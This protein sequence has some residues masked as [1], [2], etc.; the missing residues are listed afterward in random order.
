MCRSL[1]CCSSSQVRSRIQL[2][3]S[4]LQMYARRQR[5]FLLTPCGRW[6]ASKRYQARTDT[7]RPSSPSVQATRIDSHQMCLQVPTRSSAIAMTSFP[8]SPRRRIVCEE[9]NGETLAVTTVVACPPVALPEIIEDI[10]NVCWG[11]VMEFILRYSNP[12]L[13]FFCEE[14]SHFPVVF[15]LENGDLPLNVIEDGFE[16]KKGVT[17]PLLEKCFVLLFFCLHELFPF[18]LEI[19]EDFF[20][21]DGGCRCDCFG[22]LG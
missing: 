9:F 14:I 8:T 2:R 7:S 4:F 20:R 10:L 3:Q 16:V 21:V 13:L 15:F 6:S 18:T 11:C 22:F 17:I 5:R 19:F 12:S 1:F